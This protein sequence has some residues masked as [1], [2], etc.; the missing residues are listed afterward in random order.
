[1][2]ILLLGATGATGRLVVRQLLDT[3]HQVVA[4]VRNIN[5]LAE[6]PNLTQH[7]VTALDM[8][9][10]QLEMIVADCQACICCL[11]HN[12]TLQGVYGAPRLLVRDSIKRVLS[13]ISPQRSEAF[14]FALMSSTG[15]RHRTTD[16]PVSAHERWLSRL[17][18]VIL[19]PHR[20][21][22]KA[23]AL[24]FSQGKF[25]TCLEWTILRPDT[26]IDHREV[27]PYQWHSGPTRSA[28][29]DAGET[30]RINVANA[31]SRL[32]TDSQL[33]L[34]WRGKMPVVYNQETK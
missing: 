16:E 21:N 22:E 2:K 14:K 18:S 19:P 24:L 30:S 3:H 4:L 23:A 12:L 8:P 28:L 25:K 9:T 7:Q 32:V 33:W 10:K 29:F 15:V 13:A 31:L 6:H 1:M 27:S 11:G 17:L 34:D 20:D 5:V 26:L